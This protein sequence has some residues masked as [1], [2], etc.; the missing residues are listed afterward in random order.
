MLPVD[1]LAAIARRFRELEDL[2]CRAEIV[3]DRQQ[4]LKLS[5][6]RSESEHVVAAYE[7]YV[8]LLRKIE[9]DEAAL[10]DPELR[11]M[12]EHELPELK[13]EQ[14]G[15]EDEIRLALLPSD[16]NDAKNTILE[17]RSGEGGEEA[18]LF[19]ADLFKMYARYAEGRSWKLEVLSVSEASA[20]GYKEVIALVTGRPSAGIAGVY[21]Q[22]RFEGGVHR[23]QRVPATETQGRIHTSTATVAVLPEAEDVDIQLDEA[24]DLQISIAASGGP[25][26]QGVNTTNS[27]V[28]ILHKPTGM[29]VKCQDE[30]SQIKNKAKAMKILKSRLYDI[31]R[32]KQEQAVAA[33]RRGMVSTG[34]RSMKVRTYNYPQNR[35]TDHRIKLTLN[36]LDRIINGGDLHELIGALQSNRQAERLEASGLGTG[37]RTTFGGADEDD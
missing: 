6:E 21:S 15:L 26:G 16:P 33:E 31:E 36:K 19:A 22:L 34:E 9:E 18:A 30:R 7:R 35:V 17:I 27:A 12:V 24:A 14:E 1:K 10:A 13:K 23:V 11:E 28:Q 29:I 4:F 32:E 5:R 3:S 37:K 20:G 8:V 25:G 2:L